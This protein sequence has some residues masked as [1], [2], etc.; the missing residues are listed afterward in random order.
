MTFLSGKRQ[1]ILKLL[2]CLTMAVALKKILDCLKQLILYLAIDE[3]Y[4]K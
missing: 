1:G 2:I 3:E 4:I